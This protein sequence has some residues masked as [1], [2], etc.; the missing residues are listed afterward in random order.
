MFL[1]S[2]WPPFPGVFP[3][4]GDATTGQQFQKA[5]GNHMKSCFLEQLVNETVKLGIGVALKKNSTA[6]LKYTWGNLPDSNQC[7]KTIDRIKRSEC[8]VSA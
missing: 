1:L 4:V 3:E 8:D 2:V 6:V 7:D 5:H